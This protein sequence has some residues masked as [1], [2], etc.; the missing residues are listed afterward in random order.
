MADAIA[1][2][3]PDDE[4]YWI[5]PDAEIGLGHRRL[6][7]VDLSAN[8]HQPMTSVDGRYVAVLNG[9]IYNFRDL[10]R[11][12]DVGTAPPRWRGH[13]DTEVMLECIRVWGIDEALTRFTGMF[14]IAVWDREKR[15]LSLI[16]DRFGEKP[17][18][19]GWCGGAFVFA[20][21][22]G[23]LRRWPG[24]QPEIDR[25]SVALLMRHNYIPAPY[26][27]FKGIYKLV[28]GAIIDATLSDARRGPGPDPR[29]PL[30]TRTYWRLRDTVRSAVGGRFSGSER[31]ATDRLEELLRASVRRQ[32]VA[33]VPLGAFLSGGIDSATIVALMQSESTKP[34]RTFTIGFH[35]D[36]YDEAGHARAISA[37]LGTA[38]TEVYVTPAEAMS[39]I[40]D[41][42]SIYQEPFADASQIPTYLVSRVAR[43]HVTV[44][45]SGD[46]GDELFGG[47]TRYFLGSRIWKRVGAVPPIVR[48]S[49]SRMLGAVSA[50]NWDALFS[51]LERVVP[52]SLANVRV[53]DKL[54]KLSGVLKASSAEGFYRNLVSHWQSPTL[55]VPG[56]R[57]PPT[58]LDLSS[59][60]SDLSDFTERMMFLDSI[61]YLPDD[62]LVKVDRA[63]MAVGL[64]SRVPFL[65]HE[66]A[67]F[68]WS[69]PLSMKIRNGEGKWL[70][71]QV[72]Y[73]HV[74]RSLM[75]RPKM[76]FGVPID[77][78]LRGPMRDWAETLL[79]ERR[80]R[81]EGWFDVDRVRA[82][83]TDHLSGRHNRQYHL[84]DV[85]MFQAW[86]EHFHR[87][88]MAASQ[89]SPDS[90]SPA[91]SLKA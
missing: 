21:E 69:L 34:I 18:Y 13:S 66:L 54:H 53:G 28:P 67:A 75:E 30:P 17:L 61:S 29:S 37:H 35:E 16:R 81:H 88:P 83:W 62:I 23:A 80:L 85:L 91:Y 8:G 59:E 20:S 89:C 24:W 31:D 50:E 63:A 74:P 3:G 56:S 77:A 90:R 36:G 22:L 10:R 76:G 46:A 6:S 32:M 48:G 73:R 72:L 33:D 25:D 26:S 78:W 45:L 43:E 7:I 82:A 49:I 12:L 51:H 14:A 1:H 4:G 39:V 86:L 52:K 40:P 19:Y 11:E 60:S 84:W 64:E 38:H 2:R 65:D 9:E 5:D 44:S 58:V 57:E 41:L 70:L 71:R 68:A 47:Y 55:L 42:P 87:S 15:T 79:A 27:I